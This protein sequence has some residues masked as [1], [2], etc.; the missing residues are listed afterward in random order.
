VLLA[1]A[2]LAAAAWDC[3]Q[4][5]M[6]TVVDL[7]RLP[8][9]DGKVSTSAVVGSVW[10]CS[11]TFPGGG[12][13][14]N[15]P[16]IRG[17]GTFD[18]TAKAVVDGAVSWPSQLTI[19][20]QGGTRVLSGNYLPTHP[21]GQYPI[22]ATDDAY[23]YDRNPNS[24][25]AQ[26]FSLTLPALPGLAAQPRCLPGGSIGVLLTGSPFFNALDAAGRDAV[27]HELQDACQ[28]HPEQRGTYHYHMFSACADDSGS[29]HSPLAGYAFDGFGIYSHRGENGQVLTNADLDACHGHTHAITWDGQTI[30]LYHYHATWEYP[31]T[32]GCYRGSGQS[33]TVT[34]PT[35]TP[36]TGA[37]ATLTRTP[38][39]VLALTATATAIAATATRTPT[40]PPSPTAAATPATGAVCSPRPTI[41]VTST[42]TGDGRLYVTL[43]AP[44]AANDRLLSVQIGAATNALVDI[45]GQTGI[46]GNAT[47][48]LPANTQSLGFYVRPRTAGQAV[49]VPLT[50]TDSCGAWSTFVGGGPGAF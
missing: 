28:G 19:S 38:T 3:G 33:A 21:T 11:T 48:A 22:A 42:P 10:S 49:T 41:G 4:A 37:A 13:A 47:V 27:A 35:V 50:V 18:L 2:L 26:T 8:I 45:A 29:G 5:L 6:Q 31:Y 23:L 9:G 30:E 20:L 24:I 17:D 40:S 46:A 36:T 34:P 7:T 25:A 44:S 1:A 14:G 32:M 43:T 39:L 12:P 15:G 16:W